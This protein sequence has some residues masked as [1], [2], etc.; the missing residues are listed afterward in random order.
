MASKSNNGNSNSSVLLSVM[1]RLLETA[2]S[3]SSR[4]LLLS[5]VPDRTNHSHPPL[6]KEP[7][8]TSNFDSRIKG[9][10]RDVHLSYWAF[11]IIIAGTTSFSRE[12]QRPLLAQKCQN[13]QKCPRSR[14]SRIHFR[15]NHFEN[16]ARHKQLRKEEKKTELSTRVRTTKTHNPMDNIKI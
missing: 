7:K 6:V 5:R 1:S 16:L 12:E 10:Q 3:F 9:D 15:K 14:E 11:S 8:A 4:S 13:R 2:T